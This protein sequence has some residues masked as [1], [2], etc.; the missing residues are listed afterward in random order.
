[1]YL[2]VENKQIRFYFYLLGH[3]REKLFY[4]YFLF[5]NLTQE[6]MYLIWEIWKQHEFKK[7]FYLV[8]QQ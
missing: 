5:I 1:M 3:A 8:T 2:S 6:I 4:D 7:L